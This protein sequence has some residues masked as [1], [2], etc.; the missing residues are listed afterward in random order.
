MTEKKDGSVIWVR[1]TPGQLDKLEALTKKTR[2]TRSD[3]LRLLID[4]ATLED[5]MPGL[6]ALR[7]QDDEKEPA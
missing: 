3:V 5:V 2:R 6:E 7:E 4:S 1:I